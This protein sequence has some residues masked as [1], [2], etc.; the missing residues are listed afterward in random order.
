MKLIPPASLISRMLL[1]AV[2]LMAVPLPAQ[3]G[4]DYLPYY[5]MELDNP[6]LK[7]R[8]ETQGGIVTADDADGKP[9]LKV[10][11]SGGRNTKRITIPITARGVEILATGKVRGTAINNV[12]QNYNGL[13]FQLYY[14]AAEGGK[15]HQDAANLRGTFPWADMGVIAYIPE[16]AQAAALTIGLEACEGTGFFRDIEI[17]TRKV[18]ARK[19]ATLLA[20]EKLTYNK[21]ILRG[22]MSPNQYNEGDFEALKRYGA[23]AIRWQLGQ[24]PASINYQTWL[25]AELNDLERALAAAHRN[26]IGVIIDLHALPGGRL[27]DGTLNLVLEQAPQDE[28][29][30]VWE[31]IVRRFKDA[32][33]LCAYDLLNEPVQTRPSPSSL[34]NWLGIQIKAAKAIRAIDPRTPVIIETDQWNA[35]QPFKW[36][37]PVDIP[38]VIY[39]VH[40]YWPGTYTHQGVRTDQGIA[41]DKNLKN[42]ALHYPGVIDGRQVD[43]EALRRYL[44]PVREFQRANNARIY[45]GEFSAIRW[46]P[47]AAQYLDD[48]ISIFE[49]Y[50]WDWTYHA[51]REWPGWSVEHENEPYDIRNHTR[52]TSPTDRLQ[53]LLKYFSK[54]RPFSR[55]PGK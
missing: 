48:C 30:A 9:C 27:P 50:G 31:T 24:K 46:A 3:T 32:P 8:L 47:G 54:N 51:F 19:T 7:K 53:V 15:T 38:N 37:E 13:K 10:E 44:A 11:I 2:L 39:S 41:K 28:F 55:E 35:A 6:I 40:M 4:K 17:K 33:A 1:P 52:A 25:A 18:N 29:I 34:E 42:S 16:D 14:Q 26:G 22:M 43:K 21:T 23:N 20:P 12:A 36:L 49:E 45:V 5:S